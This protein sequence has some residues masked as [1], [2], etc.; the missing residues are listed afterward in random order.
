MSSMLIKN[1]PEEIKKKLKE[2]AEL[3]H[4]SVNK[5]VVSILEQAVA[6][7]GISALPPPLKLKFRP[8]D[9]WLNKAKRWGR[10]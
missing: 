3:N 6:K 4:R 7:P 9:A 2:Q 8:T 10:L 1:I 5:Q